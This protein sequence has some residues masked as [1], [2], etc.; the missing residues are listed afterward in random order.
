MSKIT[1]M[2]EAISEHVHDGAFLFIGGYI[3]R[4]P[5][6]AIHE[7]IRQGKREL[8]ITRSNAADDFDMMIGAGV[9]SIDDWD[10][11][12]SQWAVENT[13]VFGSTDRA[14][15][16][17][18]NLKTLTTVAMAGTALA[19]PNGDGAWEWKP[20]RLVLEIGAV[21]LNNL[22]T[23]GLKSAT[24][25]ERPDGSD[26]RSFPSGHSSQ[27]WTRTTLACRNVDQVPSL[28]NGWGVAL[29]TS[30]RVIAAGTS[31]ARVEGGVH[32]PSDVIAGALLGALS[33]YLV[34]KK[35]RFFDPVISLIVRTGRR[36]YLA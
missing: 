3:C 9:V 34:V 6:S 21:Q 26:D 8:T 28:A 24:G 7:I 2:K 4:P 33:A 32:Y 12:I 23:S 36:L 5:F 1:T 16:A 35:G 22:L 27:A 31:W 18:D 15:E 25:R 10:R 14:I 13:P 17:S 19:V 20:E 29:K 11:E 30:F